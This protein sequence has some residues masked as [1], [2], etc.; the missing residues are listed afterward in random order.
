[1]RE[2]G[3]WIPLVPN[4]DSWHR[5]TAFPRAAI[6]LLLPPFWTHWQ[7]AG[8]QCRVPF[9][10]PHRLSQMVI[11]LEQSQ[12]V[13]QA[14]L[15]SRPSRP[16]FN[17]HPL[18]HTSA[19]E[20]WGNNLRLDPLAHFPSQTQKIKALESNLCVTLCHHLPRYWKAEIKRKQPFELNIHEL[21]IMH[22]LYFNDNTALPNPLHFLTWQF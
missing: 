1:M 7:F 17:H 21:L 11:F 9:T 12:W 8:L 19:R 4:V 13:R 6:N 15:L 16:I 14:L 5:Y 3:T 20:L 18:I 2:S 22:L 10:L